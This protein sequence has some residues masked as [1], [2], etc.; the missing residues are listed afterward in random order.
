MSDRSSVGCFFE[1]P[2]HVARML[3]GL[4]GQA[5]RGVEAPTVVDVC[6]GRGALAQGYM[7]SVVPLPEHV[8]LIDANA[9]NLRRARLT[10]GAKNIHVRTKVVDI[11][12]D[13]LAPV[14]SRADVVLCNPPFRGY[15]LCSTE[16]RAIVRAFGL[17][18]YN[19][20]AC[21]FVLRILDAVPEGP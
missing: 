16:E 20:L 4:L 1:T 6:A 10:L 9:K 15:R 14:L 8:L 2:P 5:L 3:G 17:P 7:Q 11:L 12:R 18:A 21:A 19:E 13:D